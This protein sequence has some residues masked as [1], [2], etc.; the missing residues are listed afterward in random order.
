MLYYPLKKGT[1][2][3]K[4]IM[5]FKGDSITDHNPAAALQGEMYLVSHSH[6]LGVS[7]A[8]QIE[9]GFFGHIPGLK[10]IIHG[11]LMIY[12][13]NSHLSICSMMDRSTLHPK[14]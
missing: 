13:S 8:M 7:M 4:H 11:D 5:P 12:A 10:W 14:V 1:R 6:R 2:P 9:L 3:E